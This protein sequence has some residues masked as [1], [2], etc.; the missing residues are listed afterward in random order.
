MFFVLLAIDIALVLASTKLFI[1]QRYEDGT[2]IVALTALFIIGT[3]AIY[4]RRSAIRRARKNK[5]N[6][7]N[8][9]ED[10]KYTLDFKDGAAVAGAAAVGVAA[11]SA[12][13]NNGEKKKKEEGSCSDCAGDCGSIW[14]DCTYVPDC[15]DLHIHGIGHIIPDCSSVDCGAIDALDCGA[16]DCLGGLDCSI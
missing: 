4:I 6:K 14:G 5:G 11:A 13:N 1:L 15:G 3:L 16:L 10:N 9:D 2:K 8:T 12:M 7:D